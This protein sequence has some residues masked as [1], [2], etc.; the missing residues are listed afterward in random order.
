MG[1]NAGMEETT[2]EERK[3][4]AVAQA[5]RVAPWL[6]AGGATPTITYTPAEEPPA[7]GGVYRGPGFSITL[8]GEEPQ[9]SYRVFRG[10][11]E[12]ASAEKTHAFGTARSL[13]TARRYGIPAF[14]RAV[15]AIDAMNAGIA[16]DLGV[17]VVD[18]P[19]V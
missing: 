7:D 2:P 8:P 1:Q 6:F 4:W 15:A 18:A 10:D 19:C 3:R 12:P 16:Q 17:P 14:Q 9:H 13:D 11:G 5:R